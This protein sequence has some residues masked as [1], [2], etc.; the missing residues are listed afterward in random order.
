MICIFC[1]KDVKDDDE[2]FW[3]G[4]DVPYINL[5]THR[6]CFRNHKHCL[7]DALKQKVEIIYSLAERNNGKNKATGKKPK[8]I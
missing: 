1:L 5:I 7:N 3:I 6:V 2:K 4:L 8:A